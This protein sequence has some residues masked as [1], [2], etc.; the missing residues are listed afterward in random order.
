MKVTIGIA[1]EKNR[2]F[3]STV[4]EKVLFRDY[5]HIFV[6]YRGMMYHALPEGMCIDDYEAFKELHDIVGEKQVELHCRVGDF[7]RHFEYHRAA[8]YSHWQF[9]GY[10]PLIGRLFMNG[11]NKFWCSEY[12]AWVLS[13]LGYRWEFADADLITPKLFEEI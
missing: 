5:S 8:S 3:L 6:V 11:R 4:V 13:D 10:L 9:L 1:S 2:D 7:E 12:V